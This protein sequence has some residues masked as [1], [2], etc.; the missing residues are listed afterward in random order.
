PRFSSRYSPGRLSIPRQVAERQ[1]VTHIRTT[2]DDKEARR[3]KFCS[4]CWMAAFLLAFAACGKKESK[5]RPFS[6]QEALRSFHLNGDFRIEVFASEPEVV[7]P[8]EMV[9]DENGRV[10]V[11]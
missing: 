5:P 6:P 11:A 3:T 7:D 4:R 8:V 1:Q 10:Y 9:F 2:H